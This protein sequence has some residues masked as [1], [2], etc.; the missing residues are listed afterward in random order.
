MTKE[1]YYASDPSSNMQKSPAGS[2]SPGQRMADQ[3]HASTDSLGGVT[4]SSV[5]LAISDDSASFV[6]AEYSSSSTVNLGVQHQQARYSALSL[7]SDDLAQ[8]RMRQRKAEISAAAAAVVAAA[9][10]AKKN[11]PL[12]T[13]NSKLTSDHPL[14]SST[15]AAQLGRDLI[16]RV[17]TATIHRIV[18]Q[19]LS[20]IETDIDVSPVTVESPIAGE[21]PV[22][23]VESPVDIKAA[24][25][26]NEEESPIK[27][28]IQSNQEAITGTT[29]LAERHARRRQG[30]IHE[31]ID[32]EASYCKD[33]SHLVN[34]FF[35]GIADVNCV[36]DR[37]KERLF[38]NCSQVLTFQTQFSEALL[39]ASHVEQ[40]K[41]DQVDQRLIRIAR[42][43]CEWADKFDV[44]IDYCIY[45]DRA[46]EVHKELMTSNIA[47]QQ[48]LEKLNRFKR[49]TDDMNGR[50]MFED[51]MIMPVQRL[52]KYKLI[53][54]SMSK[55][56]QSGTVE[57]ESLMMALNVMHGVA[58]R[59]NTEKSRMEARRK[60]KLF[61]SRLDS[62]WV[63]AASKRF[64]GVLGSCILIGTLDIRILSEST[65]VKRLG[66]ALFS[67][68][69]II[70]KGKRHERY[71]PR[72][73]FPLR[74]FDVQDLPDEQPSLPHSWLLFSDTQSIE[75][76][77]MCDAEKHIWLDSLRGAVKR[78]KE[79]FEE[80]QTS[81][82][83]VEEL[84]V[85]SFSLP[86]SATQTTQPLVHV[87]GSSSCTSLCSSFSRSDAQGGNHT[88]HDK[89]DTP[90]TTFSIDTSD[91][92]VTDSPT[93]S[94][95]QSSVINSPGMRSQASLSDFCDFVT[96]T[97]ADFRSQRRYQQYSLRSIGIDNK[98]E[99]VCTT[100]IL[101]ARSQ[102][103]NDRSSGMEQWKRKSRM[104]KSASMLA[105]T[106][107]KAIE[108]E[109][110]HNHHHHHPLPKGPTPTTSVSS[111]Q[112]MFRSAVRRKASLPSRLRMSEPMVMNET[113]RRPPSTHSTHSTIT[114]MNNSQQLPPL[115]AGSVNTESMIFRLSR[116]GSLNNKVNGSTT[117]LQ[118]TSS[119]K[120]QSKKNPAAQLPPQATPGLPRALS[121][122][123]MGLARTSTRFFGRIAEKLGTI[124]TP[125]RTRR[126]AAN[127]D[128]RLSQENTPYASASSNSES[129]KLP[130]KTKRQLSK[131]PPPL[132][133]PGS[134]AHRTNS[135]NKGHRST[136]RQ[137]QI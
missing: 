60:T 95:A 45:Q 46:T 129:Q 20:N 28:V 56:V 110:H 18:D 81:S 36:P 64:Y 37:M 38:R 47:Y 80:S 137:L 44:Y 123:T 42:Q 97:V 11:A 25:D 10:A 21:S 131:K 22:A 113:P 30:A 132:I 106:S 33:L 114:G 82:S 27:P 85:S 19:V 54:E 126:N 79:E 120:V 115:A 14:P 17:D 34:H 51:Y 39:S 3:A 5:S 89:P 112:D 26:R 52:L 8:Q 31:L 62:D 43:F 9:K 48:A 23:V 91:D 66:C 107:I 12:P 63:N 67:S 128:S 72:H 40:D 104:G 103:K 75:F 55:T 102:A 1:L 13:K 125:R 2:V 35:R 108:D 111:P 7:V 92:V 99:D 41:R 122:A 32:T 96:N 98:F 57:H 59:L 49:S 69:M 93:H 117:S 6:T 84:F 88:V 53:L 136:E 109:Y 130:K 58:L 87:H 77:A 101:T 119:V 133:I 15:A 86:S 65:K 105:F 90:R 16:L 121:A 29:T 76:A 116:H 50:R 100:P 71:E 118:S 94:S 4:A 124:G 74:T 24:I 70:A 61:L 127:S 135:I 68:Y 134:P 73:W 83:A 78:S